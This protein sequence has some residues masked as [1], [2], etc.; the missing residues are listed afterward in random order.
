METQYWTDD[1]D[2]YRLAIFHLKLVR[3]SGFSMGKDDEMAVGRNLIRK[4]EAR[5]GADSHQ[6]KFSGFLS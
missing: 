2:R 3:I 5:G 1:K 6:P 4:S